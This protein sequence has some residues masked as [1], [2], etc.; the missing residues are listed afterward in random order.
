MVFQV[1]LIAGTHGNEI[2]APW[3]LE[4]S[5][6]NPSLINNSDLTLVKELGN[7]LAFQSQ[8][9]YIDRDLNRSFTPE[10]LKADL[11]E[12]YE[13][14]RAKQLISKYGSHGDNP[15]QIVF[16]LHTT[17]AFMGS[18]LVVYGRRPA[19]LALASL[20]QFRLGLP[21]YLHEGDEEQKGFL[22]ESWPCGLVIEIGP[23]AQSLIDA[24]IIEKNRLILEICFNELSKVVHGKAK[25]PDRLVIHCHLGSIDFPRDKNNKINY[26]IHPQLNNKNWH[27]IFEGSP[28][29]LS[30][31]GDVIGFHK[32]IFDY[33][34]YNKIAPVFINE[35]AYA[36]KNIAMSITNKEIIPFDQ[37]WKDSLE[38]IVRT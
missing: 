23:V 10:L 27:P 7:P 33:K 6:A 5:C 28:L 2:N 21:I 14:T 30:P 18:S 16:D 32:N 24:E 4:Q 34:D 37:Q 38:E 26:C 31:D 9:R 12:D 13:I 15:C 35:A 8:S 25:Y 3:L 17:T 1:L 20:I 11:N 22:V 36:E 19:D 29:F